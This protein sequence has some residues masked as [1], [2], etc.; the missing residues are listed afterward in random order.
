MTNFNK[1]GLHSGVQNGFQTRFT[2]LNHF[3]KIGIFALRT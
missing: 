3:N 2:L 1:I